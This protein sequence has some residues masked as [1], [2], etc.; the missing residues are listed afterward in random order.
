[1]TSEVQYIRDCKFSRTAVNIEHCTN[2]IYQAYMDDKQI[3]QC[4]RE[5]CSIPK[6]IH[7]SHFIKVAYDGNNKTGVDTHNW[8]PIK[9]NDQNTYNTF[10]HVLKDSATASTILQPMKKEIEGI[11][12]KI[13]LLEKKLLW[14]SSLEMDYR[15]RTLIDVSTT[16][17]EKSKTTLTSLQSQITEK[18]NKRKSADKEAR[19]LDIQ[20]E[21]DQTPLKRTKFN[22]RNRT[23]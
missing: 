6:N 11:Q 7:H 2:E 5:Q 9:L 10:I 21:E 1:M 16:I 17:L 14:L 23:S 19:P 4:V 13:Y 22:N 18:E 12:G 20:N 8:K 3:Y 15:M